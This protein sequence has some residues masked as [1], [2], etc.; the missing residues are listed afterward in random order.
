MQRIIDQLTLKLRCVR[1][2]RRYG[3]TTAAIRGFTALLRTET[4]LVLLLPADILPVTD[5]PEDDAALATARLGHADYLV[6]G[7]RGLLA[8][9]P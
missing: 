3:L 4:R 2:G 1:I 9:S 7:D 8:R 6:T 5:Y